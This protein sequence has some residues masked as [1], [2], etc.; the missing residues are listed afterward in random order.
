[1]RRFP[2]GAC[3]LIASALCL[4]SG[5]NGKEAAEKS[6]GSGKFIVTLHSATGDFEQKYD[7]NKAE[8]RIRLKNDLEAGNVHELKNDEPPDLFGRGRWDLGI[9]SLVIFAL[10]LFVLGK[11][12]WKPIL[13]G[14]QKR[15]ENIRSALD[16]AEKTRQETLALQAKLDAELRASGQKIAAMMEQAHR[17]ALTLKEQFQA[18]A[19]AEVL[20]ERDRLHRE[21]EAAKDVALKDVYVHIVSLATLLSTKAIG[22]SL[23]EAD[24][25]RLLDESLAELKAAGKAN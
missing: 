18:E 1:M 14:L 19:K 7:I 16:Q 2:I 20:R 11:F 24:H 5:C 12:A 22:R 4:A 25:L 17:D 21:I 10:L 8:D 9:W 6:T 23:G 3:C 15:E 13:G